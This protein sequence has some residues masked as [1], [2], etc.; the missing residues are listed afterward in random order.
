MR[1]DIRVKM[2]PFGQV[3]VELNQLL[4]PPECEAVPPEEE[5][6]VYAVPLTSGPGYIQIQ[7]EESNNY[8]VPLTTG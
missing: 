7:Y 1:T 3:A 4:P 8:F 5:H 2:M 6:A